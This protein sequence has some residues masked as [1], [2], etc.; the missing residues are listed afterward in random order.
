[1]IHESIF[2][3][4]TVTGITVYGLAL[5]FIKA[6]LILLLA[7]VFSDSFEF[8]PA[9]IRHTVWLIALASLAALPVLTIFLP[10]W[11]LLSIDVGPQVLGAGESAAQGSAIV[12]AVPPAVSTVDW[13]VIAY[14]VVA[15]C[16]MVYLTLEVIKVGWVT[17]KAKNAG[18]AWYEQAG[19]YSD[20]RLKIKISAG[21]DGPVTWGT[22]YPVILLPEG[23][24]H[25]SQLEKEMVLRHELGHI[26]RI[27]WLTQLLAQLVAVLYW[28][29]PGISR[30]LRSLSLEAERACDDLV[31]ADGVT[32]ADYAALLLRQARVNKLQATV[33]LGKPS[34]LAQ[35]VRHIVNSYVDR[36]GER[37]TRFW[38]A[39]GASLFVL[40]FASV[41]AIGSLPQGGP[42]S[43]MVL[44]PVVMAPEKK[45]PVIPKRP[46]EDIDK[47]LRP[48][49]AAAPPNGPLFK[50]T[51]EIGLVPTSIFVPQVAAS[52]S[53]DLEFSGFSAT[54]VRVRIKQQ[55]EYP[56]V[57]QRR[58]IEGRVVVEFDI[59]A[60]G[61]VINSRIADSESSTVFHRSVLKAINGYKYEPYRLGGEAMGLQGLKEEFRFQLI[62][63]KPTK[64]ASTG[65][66]RAG[67]GPPLN[68]S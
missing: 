42:L 33:A 44:I 4:V 55:P 15:V 7:Q 53:S 25:W 23:C 27:D 3:E 6:L 34:E 51:A 29:V 41:Q 19:R 28:P 35:R 43:G 12:T 22:L 38:L 65:D 8:S 57:A 67:Q 36:A 52:S 61:N 18:S 58:G 46:A 39:V 11:R 48:Q 24:E 26:Q 31:L 59:D 50:D 68:S 40:P 30:A 10:A 20:G 13:L 2:T 60:N 21:I 32:P 62:Q 45:L 56:S 5:L 66:S 64:R 63:D 49:V 37:K 17:A 16:R 9:S 14:L 54:K 47:P 1:M